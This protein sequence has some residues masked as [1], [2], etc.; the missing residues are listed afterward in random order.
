MTQTP[1]A[2]PIP[3]MHQ[4]NTSPPRS[5]TAARREREAEAL[6][7]NLRKRKAQQRAREAATRDEPPA[8]PDQPAADTVAQARPPDPA[9]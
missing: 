1:T 2:D 9:G 8:S 4:D 5:A 6:R 7:A 3:K